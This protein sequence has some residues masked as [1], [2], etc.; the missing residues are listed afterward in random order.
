VPARECGAW[1][2]PTSST[3]PRRKTSWRRMSESPTTYSPPRFMGETSGAHQQRTGLGH[4]HQGGPNTIARPKMI[5]SCM[6]HP[7]QRGFH[8]GAWFTT[9]HTHA[10]SLTA[11]AS[12]LW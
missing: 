11:D 2:N 6:R 5:E 4:L 3:P 10:E 8:S 12:G 9:K 7:P 1:P